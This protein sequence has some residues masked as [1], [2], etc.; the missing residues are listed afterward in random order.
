[1]CCSFSGEQFSLNVSVAAEGLWLCSLNDEQSRPTV[2]ISK[3]LF[4]AQQPL[5][6]LYS[7]DYV[8]NESVPEQHI[9]RK[10]KKGVELDQ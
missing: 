1:M 7:S 6:S 3:A 5:Q 8:Q 10:N 9:N 2:W 4:C